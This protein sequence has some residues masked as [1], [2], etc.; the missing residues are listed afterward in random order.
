MKIINCKT[1]SDYDV[2]RKIIT[3]YNAWLNMDLQYQGIQNELIKLNEMY[4]LEKGGAFIIGMN[5]N[6]EYIGGVG[7]RCL[8]NNICEMKRLFIYEK[9]SGRGYGIRLCN[10]IISMAT[11]L[12]YDF[13]YLDTVIR[14]KAANHI[15]QKLGFQDIQPYCNNPDP[16]ARFMSLSLRKSA[17]QGDA[18]EPAT[19]AV[20]ASQPS[21]PPAR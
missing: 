5:E 18:P 14:L 17:Q 3:D 7:F 10:E 6:Q 21:I 8:Q 12:N 16:T 15:Y 11:V 1:N 9:Y 2:A 20:S 19:I 4:G 13:M